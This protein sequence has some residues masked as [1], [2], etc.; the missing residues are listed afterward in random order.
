MGYFT[1]DG[2]DLTEDYLFYT[3]GDIIDVCDAHPDLEVYFV[4]T[5]YTVGDL[6]SWRG[7]Y[8]FPALDYERTEVKDS[9]K[10]GRQIAETLREQLKQIH[11]G[12]KGGEYTF[13]EY[14]VPYIAEYGS[15]GHEISICSH[16]VNGNFLVLN[17][18]K[19][20]YYNIL[21]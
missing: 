9:Y 17:T 20:T 12:Y 8:S 14:D 4:G 11:Y 19:N 13:R 1:I 16:E 15:C 7:S 5:S 6:H 10:T 21:P 18:A 2:E 3:L